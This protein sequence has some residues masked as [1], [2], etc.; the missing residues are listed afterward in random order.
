[1]K[2]VT[3]LRK[4]NCNNLEDNMSL[5]RWGEWKDCCVCGKASNISALNEKLWWEHHL[6]SDHWENNEGTVTFLRSCHHRNW[7]VEWFNYVEY[8]R[9]SRI[10]EGSW[11][12]FK[13]CKHI[14]SRRLVNS[15]FQVFRSVSLSSL[16][17]LPQT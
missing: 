3:K 2:V 1:M 17:P 10:V 16:A 15:I 8:V 14:Y 5:W 4:R 13:H 11:I 6:S 7:R 9:Y 12:S